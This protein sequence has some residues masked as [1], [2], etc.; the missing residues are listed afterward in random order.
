ML[1]SQH[2]FA[3]PIK[4]SDH[5]ICRIKDLGCMEYRRVYALQKQAVEEVLAGAP[6][7]IFFCEHPAV[8]T[9]GRLADRRHILTP[10]EELRAK[11]I[12]VADI[13]RGGEVT[14]HAP[15]QLV[16]YPILNLKDYG[17]DLKQYLHRLEQVAI[18]FL[19]E[20]DIL[21]D[22]ISGRTGAWVGS[23]KIA[24]IGIGVR[25][26]ISF[27]GL[28]VNIH[29]DLNL[30]RLIRPCGLDVQMTSVADIQKQTID[31]R[32]AKEVMAGIIQREFGFEMMGDRKEIHN[33]TS[34]S[35]RIG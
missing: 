32:K 23:K 26:W 4:I 8:L 34:C 6:P 2:N 25:K 3:E 27:H 22:R 21:A 18:D 13:D 7:V 17:Q 20:F 35:P 19:K 1:N 29:T 10:L 11:G 31:M 24:S 9:L 5:G 12:D 14:L 30:F 16:V 28:A 15:G 33:E